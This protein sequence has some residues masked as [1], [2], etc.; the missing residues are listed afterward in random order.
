MQKH[1]QAT[2]V[3]V[4]PGKSPLSL[5][6]TITKLRILKLAWTMQ[7]WTD[8][9]FFLQFSCVYYRSVPCSAA[10][11]RGLGSGSLPSWGSLVT[12]TSD[13]D[14]VALPLFTQSISSSFCGQALR[15]GST[16]FTLLLHLDEFLAPV[17]EKGDI[18]EA[19][20]PLK[21]AWK[22]GW[23]VSSSISFCDD[24]VWT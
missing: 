10:G 18:S 6:L 16:K 13:L 4:Y 21:G 14:R 3:S 7:P 5:S 11:E 22:G 8:G 17:A 2:N 20:D 9:T 24:S 15:T 19:A 23:I 12:S 1:G